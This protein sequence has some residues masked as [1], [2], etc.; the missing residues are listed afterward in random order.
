MGLF[1]NN[2]TSKGG[3]SR[4]FLIS[5]SVISD[6][7]S[8]RYVFIDMTSDTYGAANALSAFKSWFN[9]FL[10]LIKLNFGFA[11][12]REDLAFVIGRRISV[13]VLIALAILDDLIIKLVVLVW[14][15]FKRIGKERTIGGSSWITVGAL[16][17]I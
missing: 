13:V 12:E 9:V 3:G 11:F 6:N 7:I 1:D 10:A 4:I 15:K 17:R 14:F 16:I 2:F 5:S 8:A